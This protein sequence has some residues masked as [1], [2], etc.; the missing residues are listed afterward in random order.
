MRAAACESVRTDER[1]AEMLGQVQ[2]W[3]LGR[4]KAT[5]LQNSMLWMQEWL[6][7]SQEL[8]QLREETW[9]LKQETLQLREENLQVREENLRVREENARE[10]AHWRG[11]SMEKD[12]E[13]TREML[14]VMEDLVEEFGLDTAVVEKRTVAK[15]RVARKRTGYKGGVAVEEIYLLRWGLGPDLL[16]SEFFKWSSEKQQELKNL[17]K[18]RLTDTSV[19]DID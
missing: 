19:L 7:Q 13:A 2:E 16:C 8:M 14:E 10:E 15:K 3:V 4:N 11:L 5:R 12:V 17:G 9:Q 18:I 6:L 1:F